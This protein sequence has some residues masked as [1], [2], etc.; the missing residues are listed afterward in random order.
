MNGNE[1]ERFIQYQDEVFAQKTPYIQWIKTQTAELEEQ[2][3]QRSQ[4]ALGKQIHTLP[5]SSCMES[6]QQY[7]KIDS[8]AVYI[9]EREGGSLGDYAKFVLMEPFSEHH[10]IL[11]VYADE[12]YRGTLEKLFDIREGFFDE[13]VYRGAPWFKPEF[14]PD[15]L[16]SFFYI[17]SVFDSRGAVILKH[18]KQN[19]NNIRSFSIL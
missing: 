9:F 11:L 10:D 14:S 17:G 7:G 2:Y 5:F 15:T 3:G 1:L 12:D 18:V 19:G 4:G 16:A 13:D 6:I 8:S